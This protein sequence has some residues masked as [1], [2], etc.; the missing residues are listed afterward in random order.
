MRILIIYTIVIILP[1]AGFAQSRQTLPDSLRNIYYNTENDTI[2]MDICFKLGVFY[3]DI[4]LDSSVFYSEKGSLIAN[5]LQL[6]LNEAEMLMDMSFPLSKMGNYPLSLEV[7]MRALAIAEDPSSERNTWRL[8]KGETPNK[9]RLRVLSYTHSGFGWLYY[10]TGNS[11]GRI[12]SYYEAIKIAESIKD[13]VLLANVYGDMVDTYYNLNK[14][15]SAIYFGDKSLHYFSALTFDK[16]KF[17]GD[18]HTSIGSCYQKMGKYELA[19]K[20]FEM[21]V[22]VTAFQNNTTQSGNAYARLAELFQLTGKPDSSLLYNKKAV[23]AYKSVGN[24]KNNISLY[25]K[26]SDNYLSLKMNDSSFA[27]LRMAVVLNDSFGVSENKKL[28]DYQLMAFNEQLRLQEMEKERVETQS[29]I[30]VFSLLAGIA[31]VVVIALLLYKNNRSRLKANMLLEKQ[32]TELQA[33]LTTVKST[34]AQLIQSEKMASLGELTAGIAHEIQNPLNFVN[35]FS[36]VNRELLEELNEEIEKGNYEEVKM[37]AADISGNEEKISLHGKRADAI[38]KG[39]LQ[40]SRTTT[41]T[42]ESTDINVLA[43]EYL[44][45]AYHGF[46]AKDKSFNA[47]L[48]TAY[49]DSLSA[50]E[51]GIGK[52][53]VIPQDIGRVLLNVFSNAFYAVSE[54]RKLLQESYEPTVSLTTKKNGD[55]V[56]IC[57]A[58][59]GNGIPVTIVNKIFQPFFTTKPTGQGTGLGLSLSYDIIKSHGGEIKVNSSS[60]E[61]TEFIILLPYTT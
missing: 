37:I 55:T 20:S 21:A 61:G 16:R 54:K 18:V 48:K 44:R 34:Q 39:M 11:Q 13:S 6:K 58:D 38:V 14:L 35:N 7:L 25:R 28:R 42:K 57:I 30:R 31:V 47:N 29:K 1:F 12:A 46:R 22:Q 27:Y 43:D 4:N 45:L 36:E 23:E 60:G 53:N 41:H 50:D 24:E 49:D 40:H 3:D 52:V 8:A 2:R 19:K 15:D 33:A 5:Q 51:A 26:I 32:K 9:Y 10:Y 56:E 59:N 17:E